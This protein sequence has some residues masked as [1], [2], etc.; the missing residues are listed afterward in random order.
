MEFG[1]DSNPDDILV[2]FQYMKGENVD[3]GQ[4]V[5]MYSLGFLFFILSVTFE[6]EF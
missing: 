5:E 4:Q 3:T 1:F 2:G 6:V